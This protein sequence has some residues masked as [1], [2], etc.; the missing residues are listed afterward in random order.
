MITCKGYLVEENRLTFL[1]GSLSYGKNKTQF[2][3]W[4]SYNAHFSLP[5]WA[6]DF[7]WEPARDS[8]ISGH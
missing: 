4:R 1:S 5:V 8:L 2:K 7:L 6:S 3:C